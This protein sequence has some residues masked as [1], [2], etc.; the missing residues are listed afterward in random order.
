MKALPD[1]RAHV[2]VDGKPAFQRVL[3]DGRVP[4]ATV[5]RCS[6][7]AETCALRMEI[8][9]EP[10][11]GVLVVPQMP[12]AEFLCPATAGSTTVFTFESDDDG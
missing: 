9:E 12:A 11:A 7:D 10:A 8:A 5:V 2:Q 3:Q 4:S 1:P 6:F